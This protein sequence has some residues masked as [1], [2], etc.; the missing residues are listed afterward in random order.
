M[1]LVQRVHFGELMMFML[2]NLLFVMQEFLRTLYWRSLAS[3]ALEVLDRLMICFCRSVG[4]MWCSV[5]NVSNL[6]Q[7]LG[8]NEEVLSASEMCLQ[9]FVFGWVSRSSG[10]KNGAWFPQN[11]FVLR[12]AFLSLDVPNWT[13]VGEMFCQ[14]AKGSRSISWDLGRMFRLSSMMRLSGMYL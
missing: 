2:N 13:R 12:M 11:C 1:G 14:V 4:E 6:D 3:M 7:S 5:E 9:P 8:L 10:G